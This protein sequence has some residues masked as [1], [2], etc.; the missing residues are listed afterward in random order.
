MLKKYYSNN[1]SI[2]TEF[3]N[4]L[5]LS[6]QIINKLP[7][8]QKEIFLLR[9]KNGLSNKKIAAKLGISVKSV[10]NQLSIAVNKIKELMVKG[11]ILELLFF[12]LFMK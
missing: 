3:H 9:K 4:L 7:P 10:D 5:E 2:E 11:G 1:T 12:Y 6:D 8:R